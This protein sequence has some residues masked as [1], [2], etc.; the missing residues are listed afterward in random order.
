MLEDPVGVPSSPPPGIALAVNTGFTWQLYHSRCL[1]SS[2]PG[3]HYRM[4][5]ELVKGA[6]A[7]SAPSDLGEQER[8]CGRTLVSLLIDGYR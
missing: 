6:S 3:F 7:A 4:N 1:A 2:H 8:R 5:K